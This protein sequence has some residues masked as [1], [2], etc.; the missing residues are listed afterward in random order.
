MDN[1]NYYNYIQRFKNV[2]VCEPQSTQA[3]AIDDKR[4]C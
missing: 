3:N 2:D 1:N 4:I